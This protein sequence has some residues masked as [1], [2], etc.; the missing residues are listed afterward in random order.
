MWQSDGS[1]RPPVDFVLTAVLKGLGMVL[2]RS[3]NRP[4]VQNA[5]GVTL[6][7]CILTKFRM[8]VVLTH[9]TT[10]SPTTKVTSLQPPPHPASHEGVNTCQTANANSNKPEPIP[11]S[12]TGLST[13]ETQVLFNVVPVIITAANGNTVST[14]VFLDSGCTDTLID[15]GLVYKEYLS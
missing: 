5:Q 8:V 3:L 15:R 4:H 14:Y 1:I 9:P 6:V 7:F 11:I 2:N 13:T 10:R 12:S